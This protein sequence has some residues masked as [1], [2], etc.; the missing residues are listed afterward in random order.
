MQQAASE[1]AAEK[2]RKRMRGMRMRVKGDVNAF[3]V[4]D[5]LGEKEEKGQGRR[6]PRDRR[7]AVDQNYT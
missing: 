4:F 1:E 7:L 6:V 2:A 3:E 5:A